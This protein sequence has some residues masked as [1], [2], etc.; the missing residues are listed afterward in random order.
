MVKLVIQNVLPLIMQ[1]IP[2]GVVLFKRKCAPPLRMLIAHGLDELAE[3]KPIPLSVPQIFILV[4]AIGSCNSTLQQQSS[5]GQFSQ[6]SVR[7]EIFVVSAREDFCKS[8]F[9]HPIKAVQ[10]QIK[11]AYMKYENL[12]VD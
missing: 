7:G 1:K 3:H 4:P 11:I 8:D 10:K 9:S 12:M 6:S 2:N 5:I